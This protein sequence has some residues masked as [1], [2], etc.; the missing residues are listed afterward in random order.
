MLPLDDVRILDFS[1][2]LPGPLASLILSEAG[3]TVIKVERQ[4]TGDELRLFPP[5]KHGESLGFAML[6]AGKHSLAINLKAEETLQRLTPLIREADIVIEQFRPGVMDRLG[7][8]YE[9]LRKINPLLIYCAITGYG[10]AGPDRMKAGHDLNYCADSGLLSLTADA[11]GTPLVPQVTIAD[12]AGGSYPAV[13]NILLALRRRDRAGE[14][15]FIDIAMSANLFAL[16]YWAI[17]ETQANGAPPEPSASLLSGGSP[18]YAVYRTA[19]DRFIAAAPLEERFWKI[20]CDVL[21]LP[22]SLRDDRKDSKATRAAVAERIARHPG[23]HWVAR[24]GDNC[25]CTLVAT[26]TEAM[27]NPHFR[28]GGLFSRTFR[29][30]GGHEGTALDVPLS[31]QLRTAER[32]RPVPAVGA[33]NAA[34]LAK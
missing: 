31:P 5:M 15:A 23:A 32:E 19:D 24:F 4:G 27:D 1:F 2:H 28:T 8:G 9:T 12:I 21:D 6:N 30:P 29:T 7:F 34:L 13:M 20:F 11:D 17:A 3:A 18:R 33:D 22:A 25:C 16:H 10:Q 14:G 26:I